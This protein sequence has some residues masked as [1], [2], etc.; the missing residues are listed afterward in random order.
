MKFTKTFL[1]S[2]LGMTCAN[3][4]NAEVA[5]SKNDNLDDNIQVA[6][7]KFQAPTVQPKVNNQGSVSM[8]KAELAQHPDLIIRGIIPAVLQNNEEVVSLLLPLYREIPQKDPV[9]LS[10]AEAI[11]APSREL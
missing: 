5:Q 6:T 11:E 3:L 2:V 8:T 10:W 7:P 4:A 1:Y 9:L